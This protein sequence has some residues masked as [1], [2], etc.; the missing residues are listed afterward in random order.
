MYEVIY[1]KGDRRFVYKH[2]RTLM[3]AK[4]SARKLSNELGRT[5][6]V[7]SETTDRIWAFSPEKKTTKRRASTK[8]TACGRRR[9]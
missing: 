9:R 2:A 5:V 4:S 8:R 1:R 7:R 3:N 6:L